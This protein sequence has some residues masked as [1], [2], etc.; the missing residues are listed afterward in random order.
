MK[1]SKWNAS[2]YVLLSD[3]ENVDFSPQQLVVLLVFAK[4]LS[5][6]QCE[7]KPK[8]LSQ[9]GLCEYILINFIRIHNKYY[10]LQC[11]THYECCSR[12]CM[13][14]SYICAPIVSPMVF[15]SPPKYNNVQPNW[16]MTN[17]NGLTEEQIVIET[18]PDD[19]YNS[20]THAVEKVDI[21][22]MPANFP[23]VDQVENRT[24]KPVGGE[25]SWHAPNICLSFIIHFC[26]SLQSYS[27]QVAANAA[28][29]VVIP[30]SIG[31]SPKVVSIKPYIINTCTIYTYSVWL[32]K[33]LLGEIWS[34]CKQFTLAYP[35]ARAS[36]MR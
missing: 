11:Q 24:C 34:F 3:C 32:I 10:Y 25:V 29:C 28:Q 4:H 14:Y 22:A 12:K 8:L 27:A 16:W 9:W 21:S 17:N 19:K 20:G 36:D 33:T 23:Q 31:V 7:A 5:Y 1:F 6:S 30:T 35:F 15:R 13:T 26:F 18:L 2:V